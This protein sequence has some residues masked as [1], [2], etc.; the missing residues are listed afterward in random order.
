MIQNFLNEID[1]EHDEHEPKMCPKCDHPLARRKIVKGGELANDPSLIKCPNSYCDNYFERREEE[2][3]DEDVPPIYSV[4]IYNIAQL[5]PLMAY[6]RLGS[7]PARGLYGDDESFVKGLL[8]KA[9]IAGFR[10]DTYHPGFSQARWYVK[11]KQTAMRQVEALN[12]VLRDRKILRTAKYVRAAERRWSNTH[13]AR[14][15]TSNWFYPKDPNSTWNNPRPLQEALAW[16]I[17]GKSP[18]EIID[19]LCRR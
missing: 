17:V 14:D 1:D 7:E 18:R 6:R 13:S 11:D 12:R 3:E 4:T 19:G 2:V 5:K 10:E 8:R 15:E 16:I 9:N